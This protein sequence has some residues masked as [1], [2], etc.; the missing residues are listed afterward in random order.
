M[1]T[2]EFIKSVRLKEAAVLNDNGLQI[3]LRYKFNKVKNNYLILARKYR[4]INF[5]KIYGQDILCKTISNALI[6]KRL[7]QAYLLTGI[8]GIGKTTTARIIAKNINCLNFTTD[9]NNYVIACETCINCKSIANG[10]HPD[11]IEIDAASNTGVDNIKELISSSEYQP[12]LGE[13][14]IFIIDEIQMLSKSAF[15]A[16][17]KTLEEPASHVVFIFATTESHKIPLTIISRC[18]RFN[19]KRL[20]IKELN[21]LLKDV[22][23]AEKI[24]YEEEPLNIIAVKSDGSARDALSLLDQAISLSQN[25]ILEKITVDKMICS[26]E[27]E[28]VFNLLL[29]IIQQN[30]QEALIPIKSNLFDIYIVSILGGIGFTMSLFIG[31][32]AFSNP[33]I[34][35]LIKTG[36]ILGSLAAAIWGILIFHIVYFLKKTILI[37]NK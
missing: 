8:R 37:Y 20:T 17:L 5:S 32:L 7:A 22:C 9:A 34:Q 26:V 28:V 3:A 21:N 2:L 6:F 16:L 31:E 27:I 13:Y 12:L 35:N 1:W 24:K 36:L 19:L 30:Y 18:Q 33:V 25:N 14:K 15:N 4:P 10:N 29:A 23:A 11:I